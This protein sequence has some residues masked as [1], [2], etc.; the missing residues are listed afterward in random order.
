MIAQAQF[1]IADLNDGASV[2]VIVG[3]QTAATNV[4]TGRASFPR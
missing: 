1:T 3:T 4:W 2:E